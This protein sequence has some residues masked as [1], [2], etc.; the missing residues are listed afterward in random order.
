[1]LDEVSRHQASNRRVAR[2][3]SM[4]AT[5]SWLWGG[6][7]SASPD[8]LP[9]ECL[10]NLGTGSGARPAADSHTTGGP[11]RFYPLDTQ[12][13]GTD[14]RGAMVGQC[15]ERQLAKAVKRVG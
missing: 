8:D 9:D 15:V 1:M 11:G 14:G 2:G 3:I 5:R 13:T 4:V 12:A 6:P 10:F 7:R